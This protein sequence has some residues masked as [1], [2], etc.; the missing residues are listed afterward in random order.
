MNPLFYIIFCAYLMCFIILQLLG[1]EWFG[2]NRK[3]LSLCFVICHLSIIGASIYFIIEY[4]TL[5]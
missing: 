3:L 5:R 2:V 1:Q 4:F